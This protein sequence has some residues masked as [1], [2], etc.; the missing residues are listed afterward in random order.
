MHLKAIKL[1]ENRNQSCDNDG[2]IFTF[3]EEPRC[4]PECTWELEPLQTEEEGAV[5]S[6]D[7]SNIPRPSMK[8]V[9]GFTRKGKSLAMETIEAV[10]M[11]QELH[12]C[13]GARINSK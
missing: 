4:L 3:I 5:V 13:E 1:G 11:R 10:R 2:R 7:V 12:R 6:L 9:G 8:N